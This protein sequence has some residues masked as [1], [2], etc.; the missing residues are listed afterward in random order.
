MSALLAVTVR[1]LDRLLWAAGAALIGFVV[2]A[3]LRRIVDRLSHRKPEQ[4][5]ELERLRAGETTLILL[6]T[7]VP[8][9]VTIFAIVALVSMFVSDRTAAVGGASL[10]V[11]VAGFGAQRFLQDVIAGVLIAIERWYAVGDFVLLEP[12]K[13]GGIVESFGLRITVVRSL[14]GDRMFVP[15]SQIQAAV[16]SARNYRRYSIEIFTRNREHAVEAI[17][18]V[19]RRAPRGEARFL[20]P[21]HVIEEREVGDGIVLVRAQADVPPT[22]E[23]LVE[24]WLSRRLSSI[25]ADDLVAD[26]IVY[27]IDESTLTRYERR[28]LLSE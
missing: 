24:N 6:A 3:A 19:A 23:W 27:T 4:S 20:R 28:V 7:A 14:N 12:M 25:L 26:P 21:P 9:V 15:N 13:T 22:M 11:V 16:R 2:T 10:F 1:H 8:Y 18:G 5:R 17:E